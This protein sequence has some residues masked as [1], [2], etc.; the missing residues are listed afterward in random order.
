M[1]DVTIDGT[2]SNS[3]SRGMRAVVF[4]TS[5]VG[6]FFYIDSGGQF[7]Y[8]KTTD[9][10]ATWGAAV[11]INSATTHAA[12]DVW[13]D[14]WTPGDTGTLIHLWYFNT[15]TSDVFWRSLD[16]NGDTL[17][18]ERTAF[19][20]V[21][22]VAGR[23]AFCSGT[24][25]RSGYL[26][27]AFDIDAGAEHGIVR[28]TDSGTTWSSN[29]ATTFVEATIDQC[30]LFPTTGT[31]DDND[32][33]AIYQDASAD[34]LTMKMWDSSAAA[35]VES[36]TMQTCIEAAADIFGQEQ[37]SGSIRLSDG[38]LIVASFS[39]VVTATGDLQTW[40][41][42]AVNAGSLTGITAKTNI[43]T[44]ITNIFY[45][46]MFIDKNDV[47]Y[48]AYIGKRDN[49]E[50]I[51]TNTHVYYTKSTDG[52][53]SWSSG[54]TAY[55]E[56]TGGDTRQVWSPLSGSRFYV[57]W[58]KAT[59]TLIGN[60][61]NSITF[62]AILV[63]TQGSYVLNGQPVSFP[64]T[65][66]MS[67]VQGSYVLSGQTTLFNKGRTLT[68]IQG[69]IVLTGNAI[70]FFRNRILAAVFGSYSLSGQSAILNK[71]KTIIT[72]QGVYVLTGEPVGFIKGKIFVA[73]NGIYLLTGK[74]ALFVKG[75][76]ILAVRGLYTLS[77]QAITVHRVYKIAV[78]RGLYVLTGKAS[79]FL[80]S[81][82]MIAN[83][84]SLS[85]AG[86]IATFL[87]SR[88]M[89]MVQG[90]YSLT[91]QS[92]L[93]TLVHRILTSQGAYVLSGQTANLI[94]LRRL[95]S[96]QGVYVLTGEIANLLKNHKI[97][98]AQGS[99]SLIGEPSNLFKGRRVVASQ[100]TYVLV[101]ELTTL[102]KTKR[103]S[104]VAGL[105]V[106]SGQN[107]LFHRN[108]IFHVPVGDYFVSGQII[109]LI[110]RFFYILDL[111]QLENSPVT[112]ELANVV[113]E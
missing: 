55:M 80:R 68:T 90:S 95:V 1:A 63:A 8:S 38:H 42:S 101:G 3:T 105:Y 66:I 25:T 52:G 7:V 21:S 62:D 20:G 46:S 33:W 87:R 10:G 113:T 27:V 39:E 50:N 47:I 58:R 99:Y 110:G 81:R 104:V 100:G 22:A 109:N 45:P 35:E 112:S 11:T 53:S 64:R 94:R 29:L 57:G 16:T 86:Q 18:T 65:R 84:G 13:F 103:L 74:N 43:T 77:G 23:G 98:T 108:R 61:V 91:G 67:T 5:A 15:T 31:G 88:K 30:I 32:C 97:M 93:F 12:Y 76:G 92:T 75:K 40:D 28:S 70:S 51:G 71:G 106:L 17:G 48:V 85:L 14:Q 19:N 60:K 41:V 37:F 79:N 6:Y 59:T 107:T 72:A 2:I 78:V 44:N 34:A 96:V 69:S 9:G 24:K 83:Q 54:D 89:L 26:Y 49:T 111:Q 82:K 4:P 102:S 73:V 36:S 56:G